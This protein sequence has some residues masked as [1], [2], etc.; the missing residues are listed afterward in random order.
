MQ[1]IAFGMDKQW[2]PAVYHWQ[3]YL[4]TMME[5]DNVRKR[6]YTCMCDWV[7]LLYSRKLTEHHK[8]TI[9]EKNKNHYIKKKPI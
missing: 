2:Y 6:M 3:Q 5:H 7:T 9:I 8:P 1:T 4:V